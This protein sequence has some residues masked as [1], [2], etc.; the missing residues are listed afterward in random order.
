MLSQSLKGL[1]EEAIESVKHGISLFTGGS[2]EMQSSRFLLKYCI[3]P[4]STTGTFAAKLY[5]NQ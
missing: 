3:T 4:D 1:A 2:W 5:L